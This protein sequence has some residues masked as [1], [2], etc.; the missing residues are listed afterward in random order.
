MARPGRGH[1]QRGV[2]A[3]PRE[4]QAFQVQQPGPH[5]LLVEPFEHAAAHVELPQVVV[6]EHEALAVPPGGVR[7]GKELV[8]PATRNRGAIRQG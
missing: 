7:G 4:A 6:E 1:A 3:V 8:L 2:A 5:H